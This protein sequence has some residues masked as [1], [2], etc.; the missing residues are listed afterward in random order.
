MHSFLRNFPNR[1]VAFLLRLII[2]PRGR[3]YSSPS[4]DLG[5]KIVDLITETGEA[6]QRLSEQAFKALEPGS[7][8][9]LLQEALELSEKHLPLEKKLRQARKE[10][11]IQSEYLGHQIEEA[12]R[13]GVI[14]KK[15]ASE[16]RDY[17]E[18]VLHLLSV[19]DFSP[20]ELGRQDSNKNNPTVAES[21]RPPVEMV[22][23]PDD[24]EVAEKK[25]VKKKVTKK[26]VASKKNSSK[27]SP[28]KKPGAIEEEEHDVSVR[29]A[30]YIG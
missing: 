7:P 24:L 8:L 21:S 20:D 2:F 13:A 5:K 3:T 10:G 19:D 1:P 30:E 14:S 16:L 22:I 11:L 29:T 15:E 4:D 17:H 26:K 27:K 18:K 23:T 9:G 28:A 25:K 6:R 12:E